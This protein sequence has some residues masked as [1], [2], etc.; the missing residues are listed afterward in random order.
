MVLSSRGTQCVDPR[1]QM[2][3]ETNAFLTW[4]LAS[5]RGLPRI[6]ARSVQSGGFSTL[7]QM[8]GARRLAGMWWGRALGTL[9]KD[10]R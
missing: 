8:P 7:M 1:E 9:W 5:E 3:A 2:I 10:D 6:P 4:A